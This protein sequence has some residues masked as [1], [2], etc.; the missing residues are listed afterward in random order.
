M[1]VELILGDCLE[2]MKDI[3]DKS[4]DLV[5]TSPPFNTGNKIG[6]YNKSYAGKGN[7]N[8]SPE[9]YMEGIM[10]GGR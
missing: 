1:S 3:P 6:L 4:V 10:G 2:K 7:D 8:L 9:K 5:L